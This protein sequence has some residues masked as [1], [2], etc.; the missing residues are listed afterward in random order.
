MGSNTVVFDVIWL[1]KFSKIFSLIGLTGSVL[2]ASLLLVCWSFE[3]GFV[4][5]VSAQEERRL[6]LMALNFAEHFAENGGHWSSTI[7]L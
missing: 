6:S 3:T 7:L 4:N 2:L 5:Y 1:I